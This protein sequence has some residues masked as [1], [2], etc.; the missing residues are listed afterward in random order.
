MALLSPT[1]PLPMTYLF[2]P[3]PTTIK[4]WSSLVFPISFVLARAKRLVTRR[5]EFYFLEMLIGSAGVKFVRLLALLPR[6]ILVSTSAGIPILHK[7]VTK[8]AFHF[9]IEKVE[10][11]LSIWKAKNLSL[12][13]TLTL[14]KSVVQ[15]LPTYVMQAVALPTSMCEAVDRRCRSF[16]WGDEEDKKKNPPSKLEHGLQPQ[17]SWWIGFEIY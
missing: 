13:G 12:A 5:L 6:M 10:K 8:D 9:V 3:K 1:W 2:L 14:A 7:R 15:A 4:L 11:R 16:V 17:K